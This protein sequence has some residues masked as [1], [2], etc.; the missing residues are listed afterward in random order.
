MYHNTI[1]GENLVGDPSANMHFRNNL[2]LGRDEP[3]RGILTLANSTKGNTSDYNG[4]RP[5]RNEEAQNRFFMPKDNQPIYVAKKEDW[6]TF[7]TLAAFRT[8]T[9]QE[10]HSREVDFDIFESLQAPDQKNRHAVYHAADLNCKLKPASAAVDAGLL[11][12]TVNGDHAGRAPDLGALET[13]K[14]LP[15]W[16]PRWLHWQPFYR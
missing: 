14:P 8:A 4:Y 5:N 12:P 3:G 13:G 16:G 6:Q 9:G 11:I 15:Q 7:P 1:I 2:Y 10:A